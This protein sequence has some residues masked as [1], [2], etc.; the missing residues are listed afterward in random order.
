MGSTMKT[1]EDGSSQLLQFS[2]ETNS[3]FAPEN[4]PKRPKRNY[5]KNQ[6]GPSNKERFD[7]VQGSFGCPVPSSF[8]IPMILRVVFQ[9]IHF[10]VLLLLTIREKLSG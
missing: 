6:L 10:Q 8:E 9:S 4:R 3:D 5:P 7:S 2:P 1:K